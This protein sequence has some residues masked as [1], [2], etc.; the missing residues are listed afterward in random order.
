MTNHFRLSAK[1][2]ADIYKKCWKTELFFK[3]IKQNHRSNSFVGNLENAVL[4]QTYTALTV[5]LLLVYQKSLSRL[6]LS[7]LQLIQLN[8]LG[9]ASLEDLLSSTRRKR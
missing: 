4:I 5:Y 3:E 1:T 6:G 9:A 8:L 7:L 2:I